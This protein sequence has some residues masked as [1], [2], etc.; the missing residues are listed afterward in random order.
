MCRCECFSCLVLISY[1]YILSIS[2]IS[3]G[4]VPPFSYEP[5]HPWKIRVLEEDDSTTRSALALLKD[6]FRC[7]LEP[8]PQQVAYMARSHWYL[9]W[10]TR[11]ASQCT[12]QSK[13]P[14]KTGIQEQQKGSQELAKSRQVTQGHQQGAREQIQQEHILQKRDQLT[15]EQIQ[16][17]GI[18][19]L[20]KE[21][22]VNSSQRAQEQTGRSQDHH[23]ETGRQ[24][25]HVVV[26]EKRMKRKS[27][28]P[29]R[30]EAANSPSCDNPS[31]V[32]EVC[33]RSA[34]HVAKVS[35]NKYITGR[36]GNL[37]RSSLYRFPRCW[38]EGQKIKYK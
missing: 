3:P 8:H 4:S 26:R 19:S 12:V 10:N 33:R 16:Q 35:H 7:R 20:Y 38:S 24:Q 2:A 23:S 37:T 1:S 36:Q 22:H 9:R 30:K 32:S 25:E 21:H 6:L 11:L 29:E 28:S 17:E 13:R 27:R 18:E 34:L 31:H 15:A 5:L 14:Q